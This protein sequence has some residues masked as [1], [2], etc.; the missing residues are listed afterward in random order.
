MK[1]YEKYKDSGIPWIGKIPNHWEI[2]RLKYL[3]D[4]SFS[5]VDKKSKY[6]EKQVLLCN[7]VD[8]YYNNFITKDIS[9]LKATATQ[10]EIDNF[11]IYK[12]DILVTKDSE[13]IDDIAVPAIVKDELQNVLCGYHLALVR[14]KKINNRYLFWLFKSNRYN[15]HFKLAANGVTRFGLSQSVFN[16]SYTVV[17]TDS[18]QTVIADFLDRKT[19][20]I[21]RLIKKKEDLI[22]FYEEEKIALINSS[23]TKGLDHHVRMK[24]SNIEWLGDIPEHWEMK[25][26]KYLVSKVGSGVTPKGGAT[27][28]K[29]DGVPFLRSQ[30]VHFDGLRLDAVA[31]ISKDMHEK[32][33]NSRVVKNDVLLNITGAS[34]GRCYYFDS[35]LGEANVNQH[36]C[37]IRPENIINSKYLY[38]ILRSKIG[39]LQIEFEQTGSG[40]EG[41]NTEALKNFA[42]PLMELEEQISIVQYIET[43]C[44]RIDKVIQKYNEQIE[45][46]QEYQ[47]T[48]I[49][50]VVCGKIDIREEI[51]I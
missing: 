23:V 19:E 21:K 47:S 4:I 12:G 39:Q 42:I 6:S 14:G 46:L 26:L 37:I 40:R 3:A 49:S 25:R 36:V 8:V 24:S 18:E 51:Y 34:I 5:N 11:K 20:E 28:Y 27:V 22:K 10:T 13:S 45:L 31:Y 9:F 35:S 29:L 16:D 15:T 50:E 43:N 32:M 17:P 7:Y 2:L 30:N 38:F 33:K 44:I 41:L 48:L 1:M